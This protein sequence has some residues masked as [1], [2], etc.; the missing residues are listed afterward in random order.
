M[1]GGLALGQSFSKVDLHS[2]EL[3]LSKESSDWYDSPVGIYGKG[4]WWVQN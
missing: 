2:G 4:R 3:P 1:K